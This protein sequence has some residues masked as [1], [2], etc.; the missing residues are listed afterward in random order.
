MRDGNIYAAAA[1]AFERD[2]SLSAVEARLSPLSG[3]RRRVDVIFSY[4]NRKTD[5]TEKLC[6]RV[7]VHEE[8]PF[9]ARKLSPY[10]DH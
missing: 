5:F 9:L 1:S 7:D 8:F 3:P 10:Y 6:A 2:F 4:K